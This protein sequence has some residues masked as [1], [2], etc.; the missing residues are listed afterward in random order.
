MLI[1]NVEK[2]AYWRLYEESTCLKH[3]IDLFLEIPTS[4]ILFAFTCSLLFQMKTYLLWLRQFIEQELHKETLE[5]RK[6]DTKIM[7][8]IDCH[9]T[10]EIGLHLVQN[11][12]GD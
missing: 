9:H 7:W 10:W 3:F 2:V 11:V 4:S 8:M 6:I 1:V 5:M 12:S